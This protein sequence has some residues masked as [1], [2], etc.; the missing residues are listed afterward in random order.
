LPL[1]KGQR[2]LNRGGFTNAIAGGWELAGIIT[3]Q[4][5][6]P[7]TVL[8][9]QDFSNTGSTSPR[10][11]RTC[12]GS[13]PKTVEEW[14]DI[15]CF[16]TDPLAQALAEGRPRFGNSGRNILTGP[17]LQQWDVSLIKRTQISERLNLEFRA[18]AF[19]LFNHPNFNTPGNT[20]GTAEAGQITSAGSPR[21]IQFGMKLK[22]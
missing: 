6:F 14:F 13:G 17:G 3:F 9:N 8:S 21:D 15:G 7:F 10:P 12:S 20:I 18:E 4:S 5:G 19:N 2:F 16:T 11:D 1:G 22:F